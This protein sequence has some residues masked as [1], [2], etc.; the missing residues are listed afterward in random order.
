MVV[1]MSFW[2]SPNGNEPGHLAA[3][4]YTLRFGRT[5]LY[6]VNPPLSRMITSI[7]AT[8][9]L[10]IEADWLPT[11]ANILSYRPE[12]EVGTSLYFKNDPQTLYYT[13]VFG[14]LML[15]PF[16]L[17]G[18]WTCYRFSDELFGKN[19]AFCAL[20]FWS[21]NPYVLTWMATINPDITTTSL[22]IFCFYFFR[23]WCM[24]S[25]WKN[26]TILGVIA[27]CLLASK[28]LWI[29]IFLL[30]PIIWCICF[31]VAVADKQKLF[32]RQS[33]KLLVIFAIAIF[34]L[35]LFYN[36]NGTFRPLKNYTFVSQ[37]FT[38]QTDDPQKKNRFADSWIGVLPVPFP[39]DY[40]YGIDVQK[41][42][43]ERG[44]PSYKNGKWSEQ[45]YWYYYF[46]AFFLKT[47]I[48]FQMLLLAS[49]FL[50][51][52]YKKYQSTFFNESVLLIPF[53]FI[54][55]LISSQNGFSIHSRYLLPLL[56]FLLIGVSRIGV[57]FES[58]ENKKRFS[59]PQILS[60]GFVT[61]LTYWMIV[62]VMLV[63][64]HCMSYFNEFVGG[65]SH[66]SKY[67]LGSDLD[68]GQ[69]VYYLEQ[70]QKNHPEVRPLKIA[71]FGTIPLENT[72]IKYDG[73]V[74]KEG[75]TTNI[76]ATL[77][78]GWYAVN[79]NNIF[80]RKN[81]YAFLRNEK[82]VGRAGYSINIYYFSKERIDMLRSEHYL[83]SLADEENMLNQFANE[84]IENCQNN[85]LTKIVTIQSW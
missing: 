21:F 55:V 44:I 81:E 7:P 40:L 17:L 56:P 9:I 60:K 24:Q 52:F 5:D 30:F 19:A 54:L 38:G 14:R 8:Y 80:N 36:F 82:I 72:K 46:Y 66:G 16:S 64:P 57:I 49:V 45:G 83:P 20:I 39:Q 79:V 26:T 31:F 58:N 67:L 34:V 29:I 32:F 69:D 85:D 74:P 48:G 71:L 43:F 77:K 51:L 22:G 11:A 62:S 15:I 70:W 63:F 1:W 42:D 10:G 61:I 41:Y 12:Y 50:F 73:I 13:F 78:P 75:G 6:R 3:G 37:S 18:A 59:Y 68:W 47:P 23:K 28:T 25:T 4:V 2:N 35:N 76:Y 53:L 84:L 33:V 27:G 65:A